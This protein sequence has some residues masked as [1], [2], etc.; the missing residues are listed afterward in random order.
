MA[1]IEVNIFFFIFSAIYGLTLY[2]A[3]CLFGINFTAK[4]YFT[5][6]IFAFILFICSIWAH[7]LM[8]S[9][10][11]SILSSDKTVFRFKNEDENENDGR[12]ETTSTVT[13]PTNRSTK[14]VWL[15]CLS[16]LLVS[17]IIQLLLTAL[18]FCVS[19]IGPIP[20]E[21]SAP[22]IQILYITAILSYTYRVFDVRTNAMVVGAALVF[23]AYT[24]LWDRPTNFLVSTVSVCLLMD[25][26]SYLCCAPRELYISLPHGVQQSADGSYAPPVPPTPPTS[27][28]HTDR[29]IGS[30][31]E[32]GVVRRISK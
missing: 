5:C 23:F 17:R 13:N 25:S 10:R 15:S 30:S 22:I 26:Y 16:F 11:K 12:N 2:L 20:F 14:Y 4:I 31:L 27:Q 32:E 24:A 9:S 6:E 3:F 7:A 8:I 19:E 18:L 1:L 29:D 21:V 28:T